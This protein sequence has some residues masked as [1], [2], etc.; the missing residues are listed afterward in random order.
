MNNKGMGWRPDTPDHRDHL[1]VPH[2]QFGLISPPDEI[3]LRSGMPGVYDQ[4]N[5]GSC[6]GNAIAA[7]IEFD[8]RK[9]HQH[10]FVPSRLFIYYNERSM[11][12]TT[13]SD[14]GAEIRDGIKS[15]VSQ[16]VCSESPAQGAW[17][18]ITNNVFTRPQAICYTA[19]RRNLVTSYAR[20]SQS[21]DHLRAAIAQGFPVCFGISVYESFQ[22]QA[23]ATSGLV[24]MPSTREKL[25]GGH[26]ILMCGYDNLKQRFLVR[27]S[28]GPEWGL[29]G[30]FW[31]PF[32]YAANPDLASDFWTINA[33]A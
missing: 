1:F 5:I 29:H 14:A 27:N 31:L 13:A 28:W 12:G 18:Y 23:V 20:V 6:T 3:D 10:E 8:L 16:G 21:V 17:P 19:A 30:Y 7:A 32:D 26:A 11:E 15:V 33:V 9:N 25:L 2:P 22:T 24:P 4:G